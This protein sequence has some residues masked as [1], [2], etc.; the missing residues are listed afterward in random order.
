MSATDNRVAPSEACRNQERLARTG[1]G[2]ARTWDENAAAP[3]FGRAMEPARS[4][5]W[6]TSKKFCRA[7]KPRKGIDRGRTPAQLN[8]NSR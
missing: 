5:G 1:R 2:W 3:W 6:S 7:S 4:R 8:S